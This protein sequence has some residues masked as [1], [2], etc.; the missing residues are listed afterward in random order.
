MEH[1][2][3]MDGYLSDVSFNNPILVM[4][5]NPTEGNS[6]IATLNLILETKFGKAAIVSSVCLNF[7]PMFGKFPL[8]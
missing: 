5:P 3:A 8:K 7:N 4:G 6:L 1:D 2:T